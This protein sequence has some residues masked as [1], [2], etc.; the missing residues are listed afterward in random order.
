[1]A[2][3]VPAS[4]DERS[5]NG[6][7]LVPEKPDARSFEETARPQPA[8]AFVVAR[9]AIDPV[10]GGHAVE[11]SFVPA[12]IFFPTVAFEQIAAEEDEVRLLGVDL[13][14]KPV[15]EPVRR[16]VPEMEIGHEDDGQLPGRRRAA[17]QLDAILLDPQGAVVDRA[18]ND[19][20]ERDAQ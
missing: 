8:E 7:D 12:R 4:Q 2:A 3:S 5:V 9:G 18:E 14:D 10:G 19:D 6:H 16:H 17:R 15:Q 13:G 11:G 1:M 20:E